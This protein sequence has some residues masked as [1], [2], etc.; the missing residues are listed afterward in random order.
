MSAD[1]LESAL[2]RRR[3]SRDHLSLSHRDLLDALFEAL[4]VTG[5]EDR[6]HLRKRYFDR[7]EA[8]RESGQQLKRRLMGREGER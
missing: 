8:E 2:C 6:R 4:E 1:R 3:P 5:E 7:L